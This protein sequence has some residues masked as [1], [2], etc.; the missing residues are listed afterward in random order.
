M[1]AVIYAAK[2]TEDKKGSI[3]TQLADC[4]SLARGEGLE[5]VADFTDEAKSAFHGDRGP[6]LAAALAECERLSAEHGSC[7]LI[8]QRSDRLARGDSKQARHLVQIVLW[9][10]EHDIRLLSAQDPAA[11]PDTEDPSMRL[12]LGGIAGMAGHQES[13]KKSESVKKGVRR[14]FER[15]QYASTPPYGYRKRDVTETGKATGP[16]VPEPAEAAVVRRIFDEYVS[17]VGQRGIV[18]N[19]NADGVPGPTSGVWHQS[20]I[21]KVLNS[22]AYIGK[23]PVEG[24][25]GEPL[26]G[27]HE[28]LIEVELWERARA[29]RSGRSRRKGGFQARRGGA[30]LLTRGLLRC[31]EC[32]SAMIPRNARPGQERERYVCSGRVRDPKSCSQPSIRREL[33]DG[34]LLATLLERFVD[35]RAMQERIAERVSSAIAEARET[36]TKRESERSASDAA[37]TRVKRHYQEGRL[38]PEDWAEQRSQ[39]T[40]E[41]DAA[42]AAL[43]RAQAHAEALEAAPVV[44]AEAQLLTH[45]ATLK[46]AVTDGVTAAPDLPA[47]RNILYDVFESIVLVSS[48]SIGAQFDAISHARGVIDQVGEAPRLE[49]GEQRYWLCLGMRRSAIDPSDLLE[50]LPVELPSPTYDSTGSAPSLMPVET[51]SPIG[52]DTPVEWSGQYPPGFLARYC[53]W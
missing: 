53:W 13:A 4:R 17:G 37:L 21:S 29:I 25:D 44:D 43:E 45:L 42:T 5:V 48:K 24:E 23:L 33:I 14:R 11:F 38:E 52:Q 12:I 20:G 10:V 8:V 40:A 19:L 47:L 9:A 28:P 22:P 1:Q 26:E 49:S 2:S 3:P 50:P 35:L 6:E 18:R 15:G 30:H 39:L 7:A 36:V 34:P 31:G 16:I 32:G 46:R 51:P 27:E 41:V